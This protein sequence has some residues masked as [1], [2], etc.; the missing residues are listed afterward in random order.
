MERKKNG[1]GVI[2]FIFFLTNLNPF[3]F[4]F[5]LVTCII[6][7]EISLSN[8]I[9]PLFMIIWLK[10]QERTDKAYYAFHPGL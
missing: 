3:S 8:F 9:V 7:N 4:V 2:N 6:N 5:L 1:G 10:S